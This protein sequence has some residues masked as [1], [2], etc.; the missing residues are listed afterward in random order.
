MTRSGLFALAALPLVLAACD[1]GKQ[2]RK[3]EA[4]RFEMSVP[5]F[6][7]DVKV[8]GAIMGKSDFDIDGVRLPE[9]AAITAVKVNADG[10]AD[11]H[12]TVE[13]GFTAPGAPAAV[14]DQ[15]V[16]DFAAKG[17]NAKASGDGVAGTTRDGDAFTMTFAD[18]G[19]GKTSGRITI[20]DKD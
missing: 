1:N 18:A 13:L 11:K 20:D 3:A 6:K 15:F 2:T 12:A 19:A 5:G 17:V 9:G 14:R 8:P 10:A 16:R 7:A 4:G